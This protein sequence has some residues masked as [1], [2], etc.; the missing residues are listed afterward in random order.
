MIYDTPT[1]RPAGDR[2][3]LAELGNEM[4]L[5]LNFKAQGLAGALKAGPT[6]GVIETAPCFASLLI[7]YEPELITF[8]D[9]KIE[10]LRLAAELGPTDGLELDSRLFILPAMYCDPW[11]KAAYDDYVAKI[12]PKTYDP[13]LIAEA[14]GLPD[15]KALVR[16]HSATEYWVSALGF[17]PGLPFMMALDPRCMLSAPKYNPPRT[18]TP[19]GALGLGGASNS[20]YPVNTP[21]G[22]QVLGRTPAPIWDAE[23]RYDVFAGSACLFR[24]GDRVRY[25]PIDQD[26]YEAIEAS[27]KEGRYVYNVI[28]YQRFSVKNYQTWLGSID[29]DARF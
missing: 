11:T 16:T 19:Q 22:Y 24:P 21:G 26:E 4:N 8:D 15:L 5:A 10:V 12:G 27:V 28:E 17:W 25:T 13:E 1:F 9:L 3:A 20:I 18:W 6:K 23:G 7:H 14:N 29:R 2:Y